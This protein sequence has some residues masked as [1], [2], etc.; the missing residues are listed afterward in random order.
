[1][2]RN[3]RIAESF[4]NSDVPIGR[5]SRKCLGISAAATAAS[6]C[7]TAL[8]LSQTYSTANQYSQSKADNVPQKNQGRNLLY[9]RPAPDLK[10]FKSFQSEHRLPSIHAQ[11]ISSTLRQGS[12]FRAS[13]SAPNIRP[14]F[15]QAHAFCT[16]ART[17]L[18]DSSLRGSRELVCK[19][20]LCR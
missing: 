8:F 19:G 3:H 20:W 4:K 16:S 2:E 15:C 11:N 9:F 1:M 14:P 18:P 17:P 10:M 12:D 6:L 7:I 5:R 13:K